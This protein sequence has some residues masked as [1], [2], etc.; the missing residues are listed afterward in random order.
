MP[1]KNIRDGELNRIAQAKYRARKRLERIPKESP[2]RIKLTAIE[3]AYIAGFFDGEGCVTIHR[4]RSKGARGIRINRNYVMSIKI[5]QSSKP[6]LDWIHAR[7]G[8]SI[9]ERRNPVKKR[10]WT[11][12][13]RSNNAK[14]LL[15]DMLPFLIVKRE[16]AEAAIEFQERNSTHKNRYEAGRMGPV[17]REPH[18]IAY[19]EHFFR[20][21]K[22]LKT[23]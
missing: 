7:V 14:R 15:V 6:V 1:Y 2:E 19:K 8:G 22:Q 18:E 20:L 9:N 3:A 4:D 16:Q 11:F 10:V 17:P 21:L 12:T 23:L 5:G 13:I